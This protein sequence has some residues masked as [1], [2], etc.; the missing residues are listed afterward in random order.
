[1][2]KFILVSLSLLLIFSLGA[3]SNKENL[4]RILLLARG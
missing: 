1:M 2:K 3:C 4:E